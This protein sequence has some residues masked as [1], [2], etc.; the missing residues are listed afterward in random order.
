MCKCTPEIRTPFC[1]KLG[2]EWEKPEGT[3]STGYKPSAAD[4]EAALKESRRL[5][6]DYK[7][8][9]M[10]HADRVEAFLAGV[11]H[12][13]PETRRLKEIALKEITLRQK[14]VEKHAEEMA[15]A[16][17]YVDAYFNASIHNHRPFLHEEI[18]VEIANWLDE[19]RGGG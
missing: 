19:Q 18:E 4:I 16:V 10:P 13:V 2:C 15:L 14:L 7:D 8:Y 1:G 12:K 6:V 11:A 9:K 5:A 3:R 17:K